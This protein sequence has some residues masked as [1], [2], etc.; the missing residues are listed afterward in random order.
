MTMPPLDIESLML[1]S[2]VT[3]VFSLIHHVAYALVASNMVIRRVSTNFTAVLNEPGT[4]VVGQRLNDVLWEFVGAEESLQ[5]IL[6]GK[7]PYLAFERVNRALPDGRNLYLDLSVTQLRDP[8]LGEGL[9]LIVEDVTHAAEL[10]QRMTQSRNELS[11]AK[12]ELLQANEEL[13]KLN[14]LKTLFLSMAVHDLRTPLT[15]VRAYGDL[16]LRVLPADIPENAREYI[17]IIT[18]QASRM[19]WLID[20]FLDLD[21]IEQGELKLHFVPSDFNKLVSE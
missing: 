4:S 16:L 21:Q 7:S 17:R 9:L 3:K 5:A 18:A 20:G 6:N 13:Q 2:H 12:Q 19:D 11:L 14:R 1:A 15:A 10:E 8:E